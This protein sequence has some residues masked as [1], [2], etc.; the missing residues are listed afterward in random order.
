MPEMLLKQPGITYSAFGPFIKRKERIKKTV[1]LRHIYQNEL[2]QACF[3]HDMAY[4]DFKDL[5]RKTAAD[6][7]LQDKAFNIV[8]NPK[9]DGYQHGLFSMV[10]KIFGKKNIRWNSSKWKYF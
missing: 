4:G 6:K 9:C 5:N 10:Y 7:V 2:D 3:Q 1:N 8:K